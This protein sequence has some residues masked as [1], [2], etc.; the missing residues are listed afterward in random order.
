MKWLTVST[1]KEHNNFKILQ[2]FQQI[3]NNFI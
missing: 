2:S 3:E 1:F